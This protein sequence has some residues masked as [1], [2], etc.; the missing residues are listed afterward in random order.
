CCYGVECK[1]GFIYTQAA[2]EE[3]NGVRRFPIQLAEAFLNFALFFRFPID[4][5]GAAP[6][7]GF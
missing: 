2:V 4:S 3:A 6:R 1:I 5:A 7:A